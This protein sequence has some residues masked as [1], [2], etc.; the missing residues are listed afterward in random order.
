MR[1]ISVALIAAIILLG[2][3]SVRIT[4]IDGFSM[5]PSLCDKELWIAI[6]IPFWRKGP[7]LV[8][9]VVMLKDRNGV[10]AVKRVVASGGS[11]LKVVLGGVIRDGKEL[12]EPYI[13]EGTSSIRENWTYMSQ[14]SHMTVAAE[15]VAVMGDNRP[16][17]TDSRSYG[18]VPLGNVSAVLVARVSPWAGIRCGCRA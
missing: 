6:R 5:A 12:D 7:D 18:P 9:Q 14:E 16:W 15:Q 11:S 2:F 17:S 4:R 8:G 13:C 1:R 3:A 10:M